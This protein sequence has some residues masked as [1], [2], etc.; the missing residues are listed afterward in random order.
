[1]NKEACTSCIKDRK[2][3]NDLVQGKVIKNTFS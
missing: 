3:M 1:M 2:T